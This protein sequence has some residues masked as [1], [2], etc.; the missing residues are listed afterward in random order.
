MNF[1]E[2]M[3]ASA[4]DDKL[5]FDVANANEESLATLPARVNV[6]NPAFR[7]NSITEKL[8]LLKVGCL[9]LFISASWLIFLS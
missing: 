5:T 8:D 7:K 9:F 2:E 3:S 4:T 1:S 6:P